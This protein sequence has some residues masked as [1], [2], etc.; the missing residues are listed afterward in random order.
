MTTTKWTQED[1]LICTEKSDDRL[2]VLVDSI[3]RAAAGKTGDTVEIGGVIYRVTGTGRIYRHQQ[4]GKVMRLYLAGA[5]DVPAT[6]GATEQQVTAL[7]NFGVDRIVANAATR[8]RA[9]VWIDEL[10]AAKSM[11]DHDGE[12]SRIVKRINQLAE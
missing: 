12:V 7:R 2:W 5:E 6:G 11:P 9:S 3:R 8:D 10:I 1:G 4:H